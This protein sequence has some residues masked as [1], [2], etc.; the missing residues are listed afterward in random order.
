MSFYVLNVPI[1][2]E[3]AEHLFSVKVQTVINDHHSGDQ[4]VWCSGSGFLDLPV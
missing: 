1:H 4:L 3:E 2:E